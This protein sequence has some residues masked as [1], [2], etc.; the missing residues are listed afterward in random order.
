MKT[1]SIISY[2]FVPWTFKMY[3]CRPQV[4]YFN[5]QITQKNMVWHLKYM[6]GGVFE[7]WTHKNN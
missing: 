1:N 5:Y 2:L 3:E 4:K 6:F 7:Q